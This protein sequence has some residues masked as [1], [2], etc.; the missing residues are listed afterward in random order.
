MKGFH[1]SF[2]KKKVNEEVEVKEGAGGKTYPKNSPFFRDLF[3]LSRNARELCSLSTP[4][5][6]WSFHSSLCVLAAE[7]ERRKVS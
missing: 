4:L 1:F 6:P 5:C 2:E 3:S 7:A